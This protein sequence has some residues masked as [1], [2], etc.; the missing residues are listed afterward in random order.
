MRRPRIAPRS[1]PSVAAPPAPAQRSGAIRPPAWT[2]DRIAPAP[3][4]DPIPSPARSDL[5]EATLT[6]A[7]ISLAATLSIVL[8]LVMVR[9]RGGKGGSGDARARPRWAR[10]SPLA[11]LAPPRHSRN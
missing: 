8:L 4:A 1:A 7:S 11:P 3:R 2:A 9:G 5:T 10:R 6:G